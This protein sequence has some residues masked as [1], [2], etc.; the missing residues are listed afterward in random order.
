MNQSI[1]TPDSQTLSIEEKIARCLQLMKEELENHEGPN[2]K[3]F[4]EIRKECLT[5]FKENISSPQR[6]KLW[7]SYLNLADEA[8]MAKEHIEEDAKFA[9]EQLDLAIDALENEIEKLKKE[10]KCIL[11]RVSTVYPPAPKTLESSYIEYI[12]MQNHIQILHIFGSKVN[13]LRKELIK[14]PIR[15]RIK[16]KGF[17]R[18][19]KLG[20]QIFPVRKELVEKL[21]LRFTQDIENFANK[22]FP[23]AGCDHEKIKRS[24]FFFREEI[25]QLQAFGAL[26]S[27]QHQSFTSMRKKLSFCWDQLKGM[28]KELKKEFVEQKGKSTENAKIVR[29]KIASCKEKQD[30]SLEELSAEINAIHLYMRSVDLIRSDV[31]ALKEE[32]AILGKPLQDKEEQEKKEKETKLAEEEASKK[33]LFEGFLSK[34]EEFSHS[35]EGKEINALL[36]QHAL[37][38]REVKDLR[39]QKE[40]KGQIEKKLKMI[41]EQINDLKENRLLSLSPED[42]NALEILQD[43]LNEQKEIR[44]SIKERLEQYRK[45]KGGRTLDVLQALQLEDLIDSERDRLAKVDRLIEEFEEKIAQL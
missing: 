33:A 40:Q 13:E 41:F 11:E 28:E 32:L 22:Y 37:Y 10:P 2:F 19:S 31:V 21:S 20:D 34:L 45:K 36:S 17:D 1:I 18:L 27:L 38:K 16:S 23:D 8:R 7:D 9:S 4:W 39:M 42:K 29:D 25:K 30:L 6:S 14:M 35:F 24:L 5:L 12:E 15:M 43:A 44:K 26:L 3:I